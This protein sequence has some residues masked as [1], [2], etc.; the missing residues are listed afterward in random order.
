[1]IRP[2]D[3]E[4]QQEEEF[5]QAKDQQEQD[6]QEQDSDYFSFENVR[7]MALESE[8]GEEIADPNDGINEDGSYNLNL[9]DLTSD[10][11]MQREKVYNYFA[12]NK[13][14][15]SLEFSETFPH[16]KYLEKEGVLSI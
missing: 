1:M 2:E 9:G 7:K 10:L 14:L 12:L 8:Y 13:V 6:Q 16:M 4:Q 11:A 5:E 15:N 3:N